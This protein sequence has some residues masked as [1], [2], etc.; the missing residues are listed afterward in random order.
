LPTGSSFW[1]VVSAMQG[2]DG[3]M[4]VSLPT[5]GV[6]SGLLFGLFWGLS[7]CPA[8]FDVHMDSSVCKAPTRT[9]ASGAVVLSVSLESYINAW[10]WWKLFVTA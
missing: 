8:H 7:H 4:G 2:V 9:T 3:A 10:S 1:A 5:V 6:A